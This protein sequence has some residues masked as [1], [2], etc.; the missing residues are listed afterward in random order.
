MY[1]AAGRNELHL[2]VPT[3]WNFCVYSFITNESD[4]F[5]KIVDIVQCSDTYSDE[6]KT[7]RKHAND[8]AESHSPFPHGRMQQLCHLTPAMAI[9]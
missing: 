7:G 8:F 1:M 9:A 3:E 6:Q 2:P 4:V 5:K